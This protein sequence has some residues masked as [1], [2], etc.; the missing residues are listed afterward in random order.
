M[1]HQKQEGFSLAELMATL[2]V[3]G[4]VISSIALLFST[5]QRTQRE[6]AYI[7]LATRAA[8]RQIEVMRNN[9]YNQLI[10]GVDI[11]FTD[12][13]PDA[14]PGP[15]SGVVVVTEPTPGLKR[16]D[17]TVTYQSGGKQKSVK[18]SSLI[19]ALGIAQ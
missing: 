7:E 9:Q 6:T 14:L 10:P 11:S 19:G 1:G 13:L 12:E 17:A 4:I 16:V 15:K 3:V 5:I 2:V 8:Q 18:L